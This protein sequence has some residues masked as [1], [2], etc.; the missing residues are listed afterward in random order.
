MWKE[1]RLQIPQYIPES[2]LDGCDIM[3]IHY[4]LAFRVE[5]KSGRTYIETLDVNI[6]LTIGTRS[7]DRD[8]GGTVGETWNL[9]ADYQMGKMGGNQNYGNGYGTTSS[10]ASD[11]QGDAAKNEF[12]HPLKHGDTRQNPLFEGVD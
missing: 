1:V 3:D 11:L 2:R 10:L 5:I 12:R 7:R 4:E 6:P 9:G 8:I